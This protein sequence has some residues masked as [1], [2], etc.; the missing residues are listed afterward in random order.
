M[1]CGLCGNLLAVAKGVPSVGAQ[2]RKQIALL[3]ES[4]TGLPPLSGVNGPG[5][6]HLLLQALWREL[7]GQLVSTKPKVLLDV[8]NGVVVFDRATVP[9]VAFA[10][11]VQVINFVGG[12]WTTEI[13]AMLPVQLPVS[14]APGA[15]WGAK[16]VD[17]K[18]IHQVNDAVSTPATRFKMVA[19]SL[20]GQT[21][22]VNLVRSCQSG[23]RDEQPELV[24]VIRSDALPA[25]CEPLPIWRLTSMMLYVM[26]VLVSGHGVKTLVLASRNQEWYK[27]L[28]LAVVLNVVL[29]AAGS[30]SEALLLLLDSAEPQADVLV[31][32]SA[33]ERRHTGPFDRDGCFMA[34]QLSK[35]WMKELE[36]FVH[37]LVQLRRNRTP[38]VNS[39]G[40]ASHTI[41]ASEDEDTMQITHEMLHCGFVLTEAAKRQVELKTRVGD[42]QLYGPNAQFTVFVFT[43]GCMNAELIS[44]RLRR[45]SKV[46]MVPAVLDD[47]ERAY[48]GVSRGWGGCATA[49][50]MRKTG[51]KVLGAVAVL[52]LDEVP[53]L[54]RFEGCNPDAPFSHRGKYRMTWVQ[55]RFSSGSLAWALVFVMVKPVWGRPPSYE[56]LLRVNELVLEY[57]PEYCAWIKNERNEDYGSLVVYDA[58]GNRRGLFI[59]SPNQ[60]DRDCNMKWPVTGGP[61]VKGSRILQQSYNRFPR[62]SGVHARWLKRLFE[63]PGTSFN[64]RRL[65]EEFAKS[66]FTQCGPLSMEWLKEMPTDLDGQPPLMLYT[67]NSTGIVFKVNRMLTE[68][69]AY[70]LAV[71]RAADGRYSCS[72]DIPAPALI[73][74]AYALAYEVR[75]A[76]HPGRIMED[77]TGFINEACMHSELD[78]RSAFSMPLGPSP[79]IDVSVPQFQALS[80][81]QREWVTELRRRDPRF[82]PDPCMIDSAMREYFYMRQVEALA[83]AQRTAIA[84]AKS[85]GAI[86]NAAME[87][88]FQAG[89]VRIAHGKCFSS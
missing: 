84:A 18:C 47:H 56:Y 23:R 34:G 79:G 70:E 71:I 78:L 55:I 73:D 57:H 39:R 29:S 15:D 89:H 51:A 86:A 52:R 85:A 66:V 6:G 46:T 62:I 75:A 1:S 65:V 26:R 37:V 31:R 36:A 48:G 27:P 7:M 81:P 25:D 45:D 24:H 38:V 50:I 33:E 12:V 16:R 17:V 80:V 19:I 82:K 68:K 40:R 14:V 8:H 35:I 72:N 30:V 77:R 69:E 63:R 58:R 87:A 41:H 60:M 76:R 28:A 88:A 61:S 59:G 49:T 53:Q 10:G 9:Q 42:R 44:S 22:E 43:Y 5:D 32:R 4:L 3:A 64:I 21:K 54:F 20:M 13:P 2:D 83:W 67:A 74:M 11:G